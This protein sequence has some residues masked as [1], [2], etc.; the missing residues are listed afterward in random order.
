MPVIRLLDI[1]PLV[2]MRVITQQPIARC[3]GYQTLVVDRALYVLQ[4]SHL[5]TVTFCVSAL[6]RLVMYR[7]ARWMSWNWNWNEMKWNGWNSPNLR[8]I[9]SKSAA[10][11]W[12]GISK[13]ARSAGLKIGLKPLLF[14]TF[15]DMYFLLNK[16]CKN[17]MTYSICAISSE[18][19]SSISRVR[20]VWSGSCL[21]RHASSEDALHRT[22]CCIISVTVA[23]ESML[24]ST[25]PQNFLSLSDVWRASCSWWSSELR[26]DLWISATTCLI[27]R[28]RNLED[29]KVP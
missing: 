5:R 9:S 3:K 27:S 12:E 16:S 8:I 20:R 15:W 4:E 26:R 10:K 13:M 21:S 19:V 18:A 14:S 24:T 22:K 7:N 28:L 29:V 23:S 11:H 6:G 1:L 25:G 2:C 17:C